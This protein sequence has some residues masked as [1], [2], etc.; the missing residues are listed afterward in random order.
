M[1]F[2]W[3]QASR[4]TEQSIVLGLSEKKEVGEVKKPSK[5]VITQNVV[6]RYFHNNKKALD[7]ASNKPY[8]LYAEETAEDI[9]EII[10][11]EVSKDDR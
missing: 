9:I 11:N 7:I 10:E 4:K 8:E 3:E 6:F 2:V 1:I 5:A